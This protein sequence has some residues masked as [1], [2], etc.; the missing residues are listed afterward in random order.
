[1][2]RKP[3][4]EFAGAVYHV[5]NRGNDRGDLFETAGAAQA[6]VT[7]LDEACE[8]MGPRVLPDA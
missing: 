2:A 3:G 6:F 1:M 4:I 8:R 7:Y 5:F